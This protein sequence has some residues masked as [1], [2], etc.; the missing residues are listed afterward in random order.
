MTF[1]RD[2]TRELTESSCQACHPVTA[3]VTSEV[4]PATG[5]QELL[6]GAAGGPESIDL[7]F[8]KV[9]VNRRIPALLVGVLRSRLVE[10]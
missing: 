10:S 9:V 4:G 7:G 1:T 3:T 6:L 8:R 5:R 2:E